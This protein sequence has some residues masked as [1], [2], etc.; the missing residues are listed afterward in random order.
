MWNLEFCGVAGQIIPQ[1]DY[2]RWEKSG[3][4]HNKG[5]G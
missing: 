1:K 2:T 4:D 5:L 3:L